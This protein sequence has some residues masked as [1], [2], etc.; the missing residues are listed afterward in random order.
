[1]P[2]ILKE[3]KWIRKVILPW[4]KELLKKRL[5]KGKEIPVEEK[6]LRLGK[7]IEKTISFLRTSTFPTKSRK[8]VKREKRGKRK[9]YVK[10]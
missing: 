9:K 5:P 2:E 10:R 3:D 8:R 6:K 7:M 1:K 4:P